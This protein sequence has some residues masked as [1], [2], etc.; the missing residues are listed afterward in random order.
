MKDPSGANEELIQELSSLR[1][2]I[3][4]LEKAES[5][6]EQAEEAL[7][8]S[9]ERYRELSTVDDL[10]QLFNS[11]QFYIQLKI[12]LDRSNRYDHPL[13][14]LLLDLDDFKAFNDTFGHIEGDQV[15]W[16]LGQV[17]K[18][19]LRQ[20][21][22][23]YR[24]G[25]DEFTIILPMTTSAEGIVTAER[26]RMELKKENF[27]PT[28]GRELSLKVSIGLAQYQQQED[29][30]VFVNRVDQ[31]MYQGKKDGKD[32]VCF[33]STAIITNREHQT[34]EQALTNQELTEEISILKQRNLELEKSESERKHAERA[35]RISLGQVRRVMQTTVQVLGLAVETRDPYTAG[36]QRRTTDLAR[37][38]ATELG[39]SPDQI[40]GIRMAGVIHDIGK[41][42]L[43]SEILSKPTKLTTA[44][45]S[46]IKD[47]ARQ[48]YEILKG[49]E[50]PWALAD[51]VHQ[52]H[53]RING[54]GYPKGLKGEEILIEA[55]ILAVAD[56]VESMA[57]FRPYR[58]ALGIDL[59]LEEI[60]KNRG[61]LYEPSA[62]NACLRLFKEKGYRLPEA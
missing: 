7:R 56:V 41:I 21:D 31:L 23:A 45:F 18:R 27:S 54:S 15:L 46:L 6:R 20:T 48:G 47:H 37:A 42:S 25:G 16:R 34:N 5:E 28:P 26:I 61:V 39:L 43:P 14:L 59:A 11:R 13:T 19:C 52:H 12:E 62:V 32:R 1:Q 60:L 49:V 8:E 33:Q 17:V 58:A 51:M 57:S 22:T 24:Y 38:M 40:E 4:K 2:R 44:E 30:K 35:L 55:R 50:S 29:I 3:A 10:T 9:E 36:H 53:E